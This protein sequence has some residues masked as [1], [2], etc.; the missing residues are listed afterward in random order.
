MY[1]KE[2]KIVF[3]F[4][5]PEIKFRNVRNFSRVVSSFSQILFRE[6][7]GGTKQ[8]GRPKRNGRLS[9]TIGGNV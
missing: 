3:K 4:E 9:G 7:R 5:Y 8:N 1:K 2:N 6:L